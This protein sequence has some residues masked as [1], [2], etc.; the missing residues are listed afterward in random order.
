MSAGT[1]RLQLLGAPA[2]QL[3]GRPQ[4]LAVRK[5][6]AL[7]AVLAL[8]GSATRARLA[9][10]LWPE[11]DTTTLDRAFAD[12]AG[13]ERRFGLTSAQIGTA[14]DGRAHANI[15][16]ASISDSVTEG[17]PAASASL[18]HRTNA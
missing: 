17:M 6:W 12:F 13:R 2:V 1:H 3:A 5:T 7:L 10:L 8:D 15:P 14:E 4:A 16:G 18:P 9:G 11:L